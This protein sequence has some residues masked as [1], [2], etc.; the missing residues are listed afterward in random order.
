M[1]KSL[2][3][4]VKIAGLAVSTCDP[5]IGKQTRNNLGEQRWS[6]APIS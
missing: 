5:S 3:I 6:A 4:F 2:N 1:L